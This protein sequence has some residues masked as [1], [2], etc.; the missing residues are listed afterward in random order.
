MIKPQITKFPLEGNMRPLLELIDKELNGKA[1]V[2]SVVTCS[3]YGQIVSKGRSS[4]AV[5]GLSASV[6]PIA[7]IPVN[8]TAGAEVSWLHN[9]T[10]G[11]WK[12]GSE[13]GCT[14]MPIFELSGLKRWWRKWCDDPVTQRDSDELIPSHGP[15]LP[16]LPPWEP[17]DDEGEEIK[18]DKASRSPYFI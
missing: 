16:Y 14:Y 13:K 12:V 6:P 11:T 5:I 15:F 7:G 4:S 17:L 18:E 8:A 1:L 10:A 3:A 2:T 9:A